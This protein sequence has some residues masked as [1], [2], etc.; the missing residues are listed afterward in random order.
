MNYD[1]FDDSIPSIEYFIFRGNTPEWTILP[2]L[3]DFIDLTYIIS[4][5]AIYTINGV[6]VQAEAGDLLCIPRASTRS[7]VSSSPAQFSCFA[8]NFLLHTLGGKEVTVP[9]P[10]LSKIGLNND[11]IFHFTGMNSDWLRRGP[12]FVMQ[13]RSRFMY[14]LHRIMEMRVY[15]VD[16]Y[17]IDP[18]VKSAMRY[19]TAN[20]MQPLC[21]MEV[22][23]E[24][25]LNPVYFGS[26]FKKETKTAFR[27]YV[28]NIRLNQAEGMLKVG[29]LNISEVAQTCGFSDVFYF[30]RIFKKHKGVPPSS[31]Q[32]Q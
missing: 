21:I 4:G 28:N 22:A 15:D 8:T 24:V 27:D 2:A 5:R 17:G 23:K 1:D 19:I 20:Y 18:R 7:A 13:V 12:G 30:S 14:I 3:T 29:K 11:L 25:S 6:N 10:L 16:T 9:L 31:V 26:L 32:P